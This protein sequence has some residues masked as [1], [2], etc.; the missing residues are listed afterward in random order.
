MPRL[1]VAERFGLRS[2]EQVSNDMTELVRD[3]IRGKRFQF[4]LRSLAL[5]RPALSLPAHAGWLP[6]DGLAPVFN[7]FDRTGGGRRFTQRVSRTTCRDF[8]G[9]ALT[10][11]EHDGTDMVCPPGTPLVAAAPGVVVMIRHR[12]LRGGLT[13]AVD[14]GHGIVTQYTH[15]SRPLTEIG[16]P[17]RRGEPVALSGSSGVDMTQFFPWVPPHIH[18]MVY[19]NGTPVDPFRADG[20]APRPGAWHHG[21]EP[22]TSPPL[23]DDPDEVMPSAVDPRALERVAEACTDPEIKAEI[24]AVWHHRP[25][26][27]ALLEDALSHDRWAFS[28]HLDQTSWQTSGQAPGHVSVRPDTNS[29]PPLHAV[30]LTL[31]LPH[32]DYRG[33]RMADTLFSAPR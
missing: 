26:L 15:C 11:D 22:R 14:H 4:N 12:W 23:P 18:F 5:C 1:S 25:A 27:A 28:P 20:E 6:E 24:A 31:P 17:V 33:I 9:G 21:N 3:G 13:L 32:S 30:A 8:R 7:L 10:Y 29:A 16:Q 19:I 2:L